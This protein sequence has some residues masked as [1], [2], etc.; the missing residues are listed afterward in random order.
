MKNKSTS[1]LLI[2]TA[3]V[4]FSG[5]S[6]VEFNP[7][8]INDDTPYYRDVGN[9][10][11]ESSLKYNE[12]YQGE[13]GAQT[14]I[15]KKT[16]ELPNKKTQL[17]SVPEYKK[18]TALLEGTGVVDDGD[19]METVYNAEYSDFNGQNIT[20]LIT[21]PDERLLMSNMNYT[22]SETLKFTLKNVSNSNEKIDI[23]NEG[24][25]IFF[26]DTSGSTIGVWQSVDGITASSDGTVLEAGKSTDIDIKLPFFSYVKYIS[27]SIG[28]KIYND[29]FDKLV[30]YGVEVKDNEDYNNDLVEGFKLQ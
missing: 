22:N 17:E 10:D 5:C 1:V 25:T 16:I 2:I 4:L 11:D 7:Y 8:A 21:T 30:S 27:V 15:N 20:S 26:Y 29:Y 19:K 23:L 13:D 12:V 3:S 6:N 9:E 24:F 18:I 14:S 28:N